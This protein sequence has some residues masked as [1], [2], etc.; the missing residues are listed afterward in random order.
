MA[1]AKHCVFCG[2]REPVHHKLLERS[3]VEGLLAA[4][5]AADV[6]CPVG[7]V[8]RAELAAGADDAGADD[9]GEAGADDAGAPPLLACMCCF[10]WVERRRA[11]PVSPLPMQNLLW[12]VRTLCWCEG[13]CDSRVLQRLVATVAEPD[14]VF[15]RVFAPSE[16][17]GLRRIAREVRAR[18]A[19]GAPRVQGDPRFCVKRAIARLWRDENADCLLLPHAEAAEW[20]RAGAGPAEP[21]GPE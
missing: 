7:D 16:L 4:Q 17:E 20:L 1:E 5:R 3:F 2:R 14:N 13:A 18:P 19:R 8:M 10:Y 11:L 15:A 9:A 21:M 6:E 12:F